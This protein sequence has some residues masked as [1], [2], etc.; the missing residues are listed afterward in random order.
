MNR[1]WRP[2]RSLKKLTEEIDQLVAGAGQEDPDSEKQIELIKKAS[3]KACQFFMQFV[4]GAERVVPE[5]LENAE[6]ASGEKVVAVGD[7]MHSNEAL[8]PFRDQKPCLIACSRCPT[9]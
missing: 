7:L 2:N 8:A 6:L 4:R 1:L 5:L 3:S 9:S